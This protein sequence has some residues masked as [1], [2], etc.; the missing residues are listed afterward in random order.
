[1]VW[2]KSIL[3]VQH[4]PVIHVHAEDYLVKMFGPGHIAN[5]YL[6]PINAVG[7]LVIIRFLLLRYAIAAEAETNHWLLTEILFD[8]LITSFCVLILEPVTT[9]KT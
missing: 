2:E 3:H 8:Y 6:K 1:M 5:R 7:I 9:C 4:F